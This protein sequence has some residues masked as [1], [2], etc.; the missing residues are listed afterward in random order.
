MW[1][2]ERALEPEY[3]DDH[4]PEQAVV[5]EVYR[6]LSFINRW[7]G[8]SRAT[9]QRFDEF[10]RTWSPGERIDVLDVATGAGDVP[11]ALIAWGR[12]EG[13]LNMGKL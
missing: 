8:G 12:V 6:F 9:L 4:L 1:M 7:L 13:V 3:M 10:S 5:D 2:P 11:R